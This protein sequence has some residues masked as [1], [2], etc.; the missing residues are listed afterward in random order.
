MSTVGAAAWGDVDPALHD[1]IEGLAVAA[2]R[3]TVAV[4]VVCGLALVIG[5]ALSLLVG[6]TDEIGRADVIP[7]VFGRADGLADTIIHRNRAPRLIV[8]I[9]AGYLFGISGAIFQRLVGN[10][11]A[12]PD[13]IGVTA[14]ASTGAVTVL[15][16]RI[17]EPGAM[18]LGGLLG[19]TA[20]VLI[21]FV[22][23]ARDR[24]VSGF[25]LILV[26]IGVGALFTAVTSYLLVRMEEVRTVLADRWLLGSLNG[27]RWGDARLLALVAVAMSGAVVLL[28]RALS[29]LALGD[30][31]AAGLGVPV[32][33]VR[34][35]ALGAG[36]A[37][38]TLTTSVTGPIGFVALVSGPVAARLCRRS[39]APGVAGL[40]GATVIVTGDLIA[41]YAPAISV[42]PIGAVTAVLGG[43][44]LLVL[45]MRG[46]STS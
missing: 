21:I 34:F 43:P 5:A 46:R 12:T 27:A 28:R 19:A 8:A 25:R 26:G 4:V 7:A 35:L 18:Q 6:L 20:A 22:L 40:V 11:L 17:N 38:A 3:R 42:V 39:E 33:R 16:L 32:S 44:L 41:R 9:F 36:A 14:G 2:R 37:A 13:V 30:V 10:P 29:G 45:I 15:Y 24:Q 31:T 1:E 23:S